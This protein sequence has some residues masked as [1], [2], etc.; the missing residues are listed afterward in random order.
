MHPPEEYVRRNPFSLYLL[1]HKIFW[2][3][4]PKFCDSLVTSLIYVGDTSH[5]VCL[6]SIFE[7]LPL[8]DE[9]PP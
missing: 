8:V 7:P 5:V 3:L 9:Y 4:R 6:P 2:I 1:I